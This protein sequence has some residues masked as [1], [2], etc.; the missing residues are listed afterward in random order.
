MGIRIAMDDFGTGYSSLSHLYQ[1]PFDS[2]KID[3]SFISRFE[4]NDE[5]VRTILTLSHSLGLKVVAEGVETLK[6]VRML[7]E[8]DCDYG[9]GFYFSKPVTA[10]EATA[11]LEAQNDVP[12]IPLFP[13]EQ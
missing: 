13:L 12:L 3:Q 1:L 9:Q 10:D 7:R 2:L 8:M 6:Q 11:M 5:I 4:E